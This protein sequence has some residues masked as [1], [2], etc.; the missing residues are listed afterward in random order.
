MKWRIVSLQVHRL[1][2]C[3]SLASTAESTGR[4]RAAQELPMCHYRVARS[5][6]HCAYSLSFVRLFVVVVV[7]D[8]FG[9]CWGLDRHPRKM[10]ETAAW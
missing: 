8:S 4:R 9:R 6:G 1:R 5:D 2:W 3:E 10:I 7:A